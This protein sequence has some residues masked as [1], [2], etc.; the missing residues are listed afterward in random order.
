M[1]GLEFKISCV[2]FVVCVKEDG[3]SGHSFAIRNS[4]DARSQVQWLMYRKKLARLVDEHYY[5]VM[6]CHAMHFN[7]AGPKRSLPLL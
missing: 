4:N 2:Y 5:H 3:C 7:N 6:P 1:N